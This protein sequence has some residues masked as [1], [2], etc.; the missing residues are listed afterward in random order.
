MAKDT[1]QGLVKKAPF[2]PELRRSDCSNLGRS[3]T[4]KHPG[5]SFAAERGLEL[6][7]VCFHVDEIEPELLST[8]VTFF[9]LRFKDRVCVTCP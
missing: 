9:V 5:E 8:W 3:E 1:T 4:S 2:P 7:S 6:K